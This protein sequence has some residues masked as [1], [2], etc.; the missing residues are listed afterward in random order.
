MQEK[1]TPNSPVKEPTMLR[2]IAKKSPVNVLMSSPD[3]VLEKKPS[4]NFFI[5]AEGLIPAV[6]GNA[7]RRNKGY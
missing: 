6:F 3:R 1:T 4:G 5:R 7:L 2:S